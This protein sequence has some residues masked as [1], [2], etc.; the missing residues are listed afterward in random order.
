L[1]DVF[2][3]VEPVFDSVV[4]VDGF[5]SD[6]VVDFFVTFFG[7]RFAPAPLAGWTVSAFTLAEVDRDFAVADRGDALLFFVFAIDFCL[8]GWD[9]DLGAAADFFFVVDLG[10]VFLAVEAGRDFV[11]ALAGGD[12]VADC[13]AVAPFLASAL[14]DADVAFGDLVLRDVVDPFR[15]FVAAALVAVAAATFRPLDR[16]GL[17]APAPFAGFTLAPPESVFSPPGSSSGEP[18]DEGG[19][20]I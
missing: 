12:G 10:D 14:L 16:V 3:L 6:F 11:F 5:S 17:P 9:A 2:L 15:A 18:G 20:C 4:R 7:D 13:L 1:G 8:A 19:I